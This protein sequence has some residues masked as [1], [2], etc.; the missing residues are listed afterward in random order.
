MESLLTASNASISI[1]PKSI[2]T[3][4]NSSSN[5]NPSN[6]NRHPE[7]SV[8][9]DYVSGVKKASDH[10]MSQFMPY[11]TTTTSSTSLSSSSHH[12]NMASNLIHQTQ[13]GLSHPSYIENTAAMASAAASST[14]TTQAVIIAG[15]TAASSSSH[16][17]ISSKHMPS[18]SSNASSKP[19]SDSHH[20]PQTSSNG[21][22]NNNFL[23]NNNN[24]KPTSSRL[25]DSGTIIDLSC[26]TD[27]GEVTAKKSKHKHK[28]NKKSKDSPSNSSV[29]LPNNVQTM[30]TQMHQTPSSM[31]L[32]SAVNDEV[33]HNQI[34]HDLKVNR[35]FLSKYFDLQL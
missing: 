35:T 27:D 5:G 15:S 6:F 34:I 10:S 2:I 11:S 20:R 12:S 16:S 9:L 29:S 24:S 8:S 13:S 31:G 22:N 19:K 33:D 32:T 30:M 28:H 1:K 7:N 26:D 3:N 21:S 14:N 18:S 23:H 25:K 4:N 17:I